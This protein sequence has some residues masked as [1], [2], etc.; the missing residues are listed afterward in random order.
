LLEAF[1]GAAPSANR[2]CRNRP[3]V[4][5]TGTPANQEEEFRFSVQA[6]AGGGSGKV[7]QQGHKEIQR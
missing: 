5:Q 3:D 7:Q 1:I 2:L 6:L 4:G